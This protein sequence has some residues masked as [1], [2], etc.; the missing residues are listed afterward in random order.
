MK[1]F[2]YSFFISL[3][4]IAC[5]GG[6]GTVASTDE[7]GNGGSQSAA[8]TGNISGQVELVESTN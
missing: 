1:I 7:T 4:L 2:I 8:P 5:G 6:S 3:I